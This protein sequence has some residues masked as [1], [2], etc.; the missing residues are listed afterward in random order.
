LEKRESTKKWRFFLQFSIE[1]TVYG[2]QNREGKKENCIKA[3]YIHINIKYKIALK[4]NNE[5]GQPEFQEQ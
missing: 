5:K 4:D 1:L 3:F 2:L